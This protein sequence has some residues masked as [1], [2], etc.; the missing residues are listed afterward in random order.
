MFYFT[1][2]N[3]DLTE[4]WHFLKYVFLKND[5]ITRLHFL[6]WKKYCFTEEDNLILM[7]CWKINLNCMWKQFGLQKYFNIIL[8]FLFK[9][10]WFTEQTS[11]QICFKNVIYS[12]SQ[13][14]YIKISYALL[15]LPQSC[16][17]QEFGLMIVYLLGNG[18]L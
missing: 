1:F 14:L 4:I 3:K 11:I 5:S 16:C 8:S 7:I 13:T 12:F 10:L 2:K 15:H 6:C 17:C 18:K 9:C